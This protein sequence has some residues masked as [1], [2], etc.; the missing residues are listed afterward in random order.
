MLRF[1]RQLRKD[2]FMSN[3]SR[4]YILYALGEILLVMIG[5]LLALQVNNWNEERKEQKLSQDILGQIASK[6]ETDTLVLN[7]QQARFKIMRD[8]ALWL[9]EQFEQDAPWV[10]RMDTALARISMFSISE[11]DYTAFNYLENVGIGIIKDQDLRDQISTYYSWSKDIAETDDYFEVNKY[12]RHEIY[13]KYFKRYQY[14]TYVKP[15]DYEALKKSD[16]FRVVLDVCLNDTRYYLAR[17]NWQ[18]EQAQMILK[19]IHQTLKN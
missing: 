13:P 5:I 17:T 3:K 4:N 8:D 10:P 14:A 15:V 19:M 1:F 18:L 16:E 6:M 2:H 11:A 9:I 12:F 7:R